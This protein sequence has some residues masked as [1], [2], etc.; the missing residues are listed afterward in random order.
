MGNMRERESMWARRVRESMRGNW[1][2]DEWVWEGPRGRWIGRL[3]G[4]CWEGFVRMVGTFGGGFSPRSLFPSAAAKTG[5]CGDKV[6]VG[7]CGKV[8]G[9]SR[10]GRR[11]EGGA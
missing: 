5:A 8:G 6:G 9:E 4:L 3:G 10:C 1:V 11:M 7:E 2:W